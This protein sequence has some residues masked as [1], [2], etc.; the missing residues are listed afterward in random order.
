MPNGFVL[1]KQKTRV[2]SSSYQMENLPLKTCRDKL[3]HK[4]ARLAV[5]IDLGLYCV[6]KIRGERKTRCMI[7]LNVQIFRYFN[8]NFHT[9][10]KIESNS[11]DLFIASEDKHELVI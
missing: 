11:M 9:R 5:E 6:V 7:K 8:L 10:T 4:S 1:I 2:S 3:V